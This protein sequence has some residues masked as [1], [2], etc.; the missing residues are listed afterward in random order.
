MDVDVARSEV[1][2]PA[3]DASGTGMS[4]LELTT[5]GE[6][7]PISNVFVPGFLDVAVAASGTTFLVGANR[8]YAV[9]QGTGDRAEVLGKVS[10]SQGA[11]RL[12]IVNARAYV[13]TDQDGLGT[14]VH[15]QIVDIADPTNMQLL[16]S[17]SLGNYHFPFLAT[18]KRFFVEGNTL[19]V[20]TLTGL[21]LYDASD[22]T[23][24]RQLGSFATPSV[25]ENVLVRDGIAYVITHR[26]KGF[27]RRIDLYVVDVSKPARPKLK[28]K[29]RNVDV[30]DFVTELQ[31]QD[32]RLFMVDTGGGDGTLFF[33][34]GKLLVVNIDDPSAPRLES[35]I[36]TRP[37]RLS[38]AVDIFVTGDIAY[39]ADGIDGV[40]LY[41][42]KGGGT[43][44]FLRTIDTPDFANGVWV[45]ETGNLSV[46]DRSSYQ[47][48]PVSP[49]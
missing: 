40:S 16:G 1:F 6:L 38:Y 13:Y 9:R 39:I 22:P 34:D 33:I 45:D 32:R 25:A 46:A 20:V 27:F 37:S 18:S 17:L 11:S 49:H 28:G 15:I 26:L 19:Y 43:P 7:T 31:I 4:I 10:L 2:M 5:N 14:D 23:Q 42:I 44:E 3:W 8:L 21:V 47:V 12:Q 41:S 24:P 48:Y 29:L 35:K 30:A 36:R